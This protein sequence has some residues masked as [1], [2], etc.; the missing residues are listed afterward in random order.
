MLPL[1]LFLAGNWDHT[2]SVR[3]EVVGIWSLEGGGFL[4][5]AEKHSSCRHFFEQLVKV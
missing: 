1:L 2:S 4:S 3:E 5:E